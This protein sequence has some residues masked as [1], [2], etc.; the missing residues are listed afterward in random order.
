MAGRLCQLTCALFFFSILPAGFLAAA[1]P[2]AITNVTVIDGTGKPARHGM[3]VVI[4]GGHI[5]AITPAR[6]AKFPRGTRVV[7]GEGRFLIPG[8]WD[9]HVHGLGGPRDEANSKWMFPLEIANGIVGVRLMAGP[10]DASAWR[11]EHASTAQ[12]SPAVF[13]ASPVIDGKQYWPGSVVAAG[14]AQG[15]AFVAGQKD[16]GADFI[17]VYSFLSRD[18]FLAI[19]DEASKRHIPFAGHV[20]YSVRASEASDAGMKSIEHLTMVALS[21]SSREDELFEKLQSGSGAAVEAQAHESF[22]ESKAKA[23]F[24]RFV[25]NGAWQCPTL[26]VIRS[27]SR[28][29]NPAEL[30]KDERL[31]YVPE[32][33]HQRW[34]PRNDF[35]FKKADAAYWEFARRNFR[36]AMDL[37]GR[38]HHAG[39][40][41]LAGTDV[42]N[43]YLY[44]GFSL[45]EELELL[46]QAGLPAQEALQSATRKAAEFMGQS[47]IRGTIE[48]GKIA[49]LVLVDRDPLADIRNTRLV[50]AVVLNGKLLERSM[51]DKMLAEV[52]AL[53]RQ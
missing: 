19:A 9:M 39:V 14:A 8:L 46:V 32:G 6:R 51:L 24:A 27:L 21:C 26:S 15:R 50:H 35:R 30:E 40:A 53:A 31:K 37:V 44:P 25:R 7:E 22:D 52:Q 47:D 41:I 38:M 48:T 36:G 10:P 45:H 49:D 34:D 42:G 16:R 11:A 13:V 33:N 28:L 17:K 29:D 1:E 4:T 18:S 43:P 2:L 23:L 5:T 20:P 3:T 12:L